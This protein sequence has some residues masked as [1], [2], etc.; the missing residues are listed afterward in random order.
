[1]SSQGMLD[2]ARVLIIYYSRSGNTEKMAKLVADGVL[3]EKKV[4]VEVKPVKDVQV[5]ELL[6][7]DGII[8]GS[9]TYYG[10][11]ASE[12]KKLL[13]DSIKFHG[14]LDGKIGGAFSSSGNIGG[15]NET[16]I[17]NILKALLIHG[18][19]VQGTPRGDHYGPVAIKEPDER[20]KR[21]C[22]EYGLR[23]AKLVLK[24]SHA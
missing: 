21:L 10:S 17:M 16:T 18:M 4:E 12:I 2:M 9:P 5:E 3:K 19:I 8:I 22:I 24:L 14:K 20:S 23:I 7:A 11:M 13:D 6:D 1:L 15:G